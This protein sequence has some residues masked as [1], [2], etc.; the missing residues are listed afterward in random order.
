MKKFLA[1]T[2]S[3]VTICA[4][5]PYSAVAAWE[6]LPVETS[7]LI[8]IEDLSLLHGEIGAIHRTTQFVGLAVRCEE[9][10]PAQTQIGD[11]NAYLFTVDQP[12]QNQINYE[13]VYADSAAYFV[14]TYDFWMQTMQDAV[15]EYHESYF[16]IE[17]V[18]P[19]E[20]VLDTK[21]IDTSDLYVVFCRGTLPSQDE[22]NSSYDVMADAL[23]QDGRFSYVGEAH[24]VRQQ[25]AYLDNM[26]TAVCESTE[27][28]ANLAETLSQ[29]YCVQYG[30]EVHFYRL[31]EDNANYT[32]YTQT[33][34][35]VAE[36]RSFCDMLLDQDGV[37]DAFCSYSVLEIISEARGEI[38]LP[39]ASQTVN[40]LG[41][42]DGNGTIDT[43]DAKLV[44]QA[45]VHTMFDSNALTTE[46]R[47]RADVTN[48]GVIDSADAILIL[49][50]YNRVT[51]FGEADLTFEQLMN[52]A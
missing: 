20:T 21:Y 1:C 4:A 41:D 40:A 39:S 25:P 35:S 43:A 9:E 3:A 19:N 49:R 33:F 50:Y 17:G 2:L 31:Y 16:E 44:L 46:E 29:Y 13:A 48:D 34:E 30:E 11:V 26:I 5:F 38:I 51:I 27:A 22:S 47:V 36:A 6:K 18:L 15:A 8:E 14:Y 42:I 52:E 7:Y 10:M 28:A 24:A 12:E 23:Q 32:L 45:Y 37:T